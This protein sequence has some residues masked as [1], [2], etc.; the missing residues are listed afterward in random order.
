MPRPQIFQAKDGILASLTGNF[1][2]AGDVTLDIRYN[3]STLDKHES[4]G[5][6]SLPK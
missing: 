4:S 3:E 2:I 6:L 5:H 1:T